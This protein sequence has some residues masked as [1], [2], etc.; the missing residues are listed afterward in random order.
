MHRLW[1]PLVL[2]LLATRAMAGDIGAVVTVS[3]AEG[4]PG[5]EVDLHVRLDIGA[6][7]PIVRFYSDLD[8]PT[9]FITVRRLPNGEPDCAV[10]P[11]FTKQ[12]PNNAVFNCIT[13]D[14]SKTRCI[15]SRASIVGIQGD[16]FFPS[17]RIY[18]CP[19]VI[20]PNAPPGPYTVGI[21]AVRLCPNARDSD[22]FPPAQR[23]SGIV[24]VVQPTPTPTA[25]VT[26]TPTGTP[27]NTPTETP[28]PSPTR[29]GTNT[30]SPG[31]RTPTGTRTKTG[32]RTVSP[33]ITLSPTITPTPGLAIQ[34]NADPVRPGDFAE[35]I[36]DIVDRTMQAASTGFDLLLS[37]DVFDLTDFSTACTIA[38]RLVNHLLGVSVAPEPP[39]PGMRRLRFVINNNPVRPIELIRTGRLVTCLLPI[40]AAA[41]AGPTELML[42]RLFAGNQN[43][44]LIPGIAGID[45]ELE[46]D[47]EAPVPT[48]TASG[49]R[50]ATPT[51]TP[52]VAASPT[53]TPLPTGSATA[54]PTASP[55][56]R[57]SLCTGDCDGDGFAR[58]D[59]LV[60][61]VEIA[62]GKGPLAGCTIID[63]NRDEA[64]TIDELVVA[65]RD[66]M[67]GCPE[68]AP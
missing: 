14:A 46:V 26:S 17:A 57:I 42:D 68:T 44:M 52:S 59:E 47:P 27:T 54:T 38:P 3:N 28:T 45:G 64:V 56:G 5:S 29:T 49:S 2:I 61:A 65:V 35:L 13:E 9:P 43:G 6:S 20:A 12:V 11:A 31:T 41:P 24:T 18:T 23:I 15:E 22:C 32:T 66:A 51:R 7:P 40:A 19:F 30:P 37:Q 58:I 53:R 55:T 39:P 25:T 62:L 21:E 50:T 60:R 16:I 63:R 33:T 67:Q 36:F 10:E 8:S 48:N 4:V 1:L 34:V